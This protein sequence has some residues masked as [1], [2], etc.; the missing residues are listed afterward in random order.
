MD[1]ESEEREKNNTK[2]KKGFLIDSI[3]IR[4][5]KQKM[6]SCRYNKVILERGPRS[7]YGS[8]KTCTP[9]ALAPG[10]SVIVPVARLVDE[11]LQRFT[12]SRYPL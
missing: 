5:N 1:I 4:R 9:L 10:G 2:N 6:R 3:I 11:V 12:D 8:P 7:S